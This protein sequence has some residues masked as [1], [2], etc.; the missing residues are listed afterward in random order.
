MAAQV[1]PAIEG[2]LPERGAK[3]E[4]AGG[5]GAS[6]PGASAQEVDDAPAIKDDDDDEAEGAVWETASLLEEILDDVAAF[7]Y[8]SH[9]RRISLTTMSRC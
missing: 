7:E 4:A 5:G 9:S 3:A 8:S 6:A 2:A 1:P